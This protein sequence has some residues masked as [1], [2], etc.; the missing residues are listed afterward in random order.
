[1][2]PVVIRIN[3]RPLTPAQIAEARALRA[4]GKSYLQIATIIGCKQSQII[5]ALRG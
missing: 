1:M 5:K 3:A 4:A 2:R